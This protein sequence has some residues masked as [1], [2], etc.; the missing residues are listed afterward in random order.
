MDEEGK[1]KKRVEKRK[2]EYVCPEGIQPCNTKNRDI[3]YRR[4][5]T[6]ETLYIGQ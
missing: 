2:N 5:T 4:Y 6:Q 1:G 3:Y